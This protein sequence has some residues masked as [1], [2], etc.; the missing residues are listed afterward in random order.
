MLRLALRLAWDWGVP[1]T[2]LLGARLLL[3]GMGAQSWAEGLWLFPDF[4][5][6]LWTFSLVML[7][8][9]ATRLVLLRHVLR[10]T[11]GEHR[12]VAPATATSRRPT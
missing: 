4:I 7:L 2:L 11:S 9:G 1:L 10:R 6:W 3:G 5:G 12:L 8:T